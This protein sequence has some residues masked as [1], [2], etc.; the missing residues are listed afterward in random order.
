MGIR[1]VN[2]MKELKII[3]YFP[4]SHFWKLWEKRIPEVILTETDDK[5]TSEHFYLNGTLKRK[6][7]KWSNGDS[8]EKKYL[9]TGRLFEETDRKGNEIR[10]ILIG[11]RNEIICDERINEKTRTETHYYPNG[12]L[13]MRHSRKTGEYEEWTDTG[14][15]KKKGRWCYTNGRPADLKDKFARFETGNMRIKEQD[16]QR[17]EYIDVIDTINSLPVTSGRQIAKRA[18]VREY[19]KS[20][21]KE[22]N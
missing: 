1:K 12:K 3:T 13:K 21:C 15:L 19:R 22:R 5:A 9:S 7:I 17:Q 14:V 16:E 2:S 6:Y 20:L 4:R 18:L 10:Y 8:I 11:E